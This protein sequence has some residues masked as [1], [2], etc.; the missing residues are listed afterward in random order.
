MGDAFP[1]LSNS[2]GVVYT[3]YPSWAKGAPPANCVPAVDTAAP[4][5]AGDVSALKGASSP[6]P[7]L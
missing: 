3:D 1:S 2:L 7:L 5:T 6:S 4:A